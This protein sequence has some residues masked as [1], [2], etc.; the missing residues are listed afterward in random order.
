MRNKTSTKEVI[1]SFLEE[2]R[3][4]KKEARFDRFFKIKV[5]K[6]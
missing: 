2:T 6:S 1:L 4:N 5:F 3:G